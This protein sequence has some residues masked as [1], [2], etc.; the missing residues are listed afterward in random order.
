MPED[1]GY[2]NKGGRNFINSRRPYTSKEQPLR[3]GAQMLADNAKH[4][5]NGKTHRAAVSTKPL[6]VGPQ[7][8]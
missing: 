2:P 1:K 3:T 5:G 6:R 8:T 7:K 4:P